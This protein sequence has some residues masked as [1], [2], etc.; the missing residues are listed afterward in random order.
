MSSLS[1]YSHKKAVETLNEPEEEAAGAIIIQSLRQKIE[2]DV[3]VQRM[4][5]MEWALLG[6]IRQAKWDLDKAYAKMKKLS[7]FMDEHKGLFENQNPEVFRTIAKIGVSS[8][9]PTRNNRGELVLLMHGEAMTE[10]AQKCT[11]DDLLRFSTWNT[12][13]TLSGTEGE[14]TSINGC[15]LIENLENYP[16]TALNSMAGVSYGGM[17]A[18]FDFLNV[19]PLRIRGIYAFKQPWYIGMMVSMMWPF[20]SSK[21]YSRVK[22]YGTDSTRMLKDAGLKPEQVPILY[23][24]TMPNEQFEPDWYLE[25][26]G[27]TWRET[28]KAETGGA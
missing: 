24:G 26:S 21:L 19:T 18:S 7:V 1:E 17:R 25:R 27:D 12:I 13:Q 11:M 9:L 10:L 15:I 6:A 2:S 20:M 14:Q 4:A 5:A 28:G 23:G 8:K 22:L 3:G 16:M